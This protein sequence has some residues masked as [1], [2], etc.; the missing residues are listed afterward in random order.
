MKITH[1]GWK[2]FA[3]LA[4]LAALAGCGPASENGASGGTAPAAADPTPAGRLV[5]TERG[6]YRDISPAE[7]QAMLEH[8]DFFHVDVHVPHEG[9]LPA[10]DARIPYDRIAE[11]LDA[12]P[13]DKSAKIVVT[14]R[15]DHMSTIASEVLADLGY[16]NI[17]NLDGGFNAWRDAGYPFYP[18]ET[19]TP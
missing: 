10:I 17:Y 7:F 18:E 13:A 2:M 4:L 19:P 8:K 16:T 11:R 9:R 12:L 3:L 15:S 1:A 5:T 14:C 6:Q